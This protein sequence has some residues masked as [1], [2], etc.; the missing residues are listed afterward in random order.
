MGVGGANAAL[1][2]VQADDLIKSFKILNKTNATKP[3][4]KKILSYMKD[5]GINI[6]TETAQEVGQEASTIIGVQAA[7]KIEKGKFA[8]DASEVARRLGETAASSALSFGLLGTGGD[9]VKT[10]VNRMLDTAAAMAKLI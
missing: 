9:V 3:V 2:M 10:G 1:E 4:A 7:N 6:A 8:Y 5:R